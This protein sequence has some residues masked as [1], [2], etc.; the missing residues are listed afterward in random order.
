MMSFEGDPIITWLLEGDP[1]IRWQVHA[2]LLE[3]GAEVVEQERARIAEEGW[4]AALLA[5]QTPD[6]RWGNGLYSPKWTSTTYTLLLLRDLGLMSGNQQALAGCRLLLDQGLYDDGG[7]NFWKS[8][9]HSETCVTSMVLSILAYFKLPDE[10][11]SRLVEHLLEQQMPDG[12][13]NCRRI[14]GAVHSSF[15]TTILALEGLWHFART[16]PAFASEINEAEA[17]GREFLLQHRLY[18]S[19]KTG[20]I[21]N[22]AFTR[23]AYPTRWHHDVLRALDYWQVSRS[24]R[25]ERL[26][27]GIDLVYKKRETDGRWVLQYRYSGKTFFEMERV[28]KPSRWNTLRA[29]RVLKWWE[30]V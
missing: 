13:W 3:S 11:V 8:Y 10:R 2:D 14:R 17:R 6:G 24:M 15:N 29:L 25:D 9:R 26:Q 1:A 4:G 5:K 18:R 20:N 22:T 23:F 30:V 7:I 16:H 19:D 28:G 27:D 21:V 12:G